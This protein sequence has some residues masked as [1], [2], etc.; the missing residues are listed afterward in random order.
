YHY[1]KDAIPELIVTGTIFQF[2]CISSITKASP[3]DPTKHVRLDHA[4]PNL[5]L[6]AP[7]VACVEFAPSIAVTVADG[8]HVLD[9]VRRLS[10]PFIRRVPASPTLQA[11]LALF[12]RYWSN[13]AKTTATSSE[14]PDERVD[15]CPKSQRHLRPRRVIVAA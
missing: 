4:D 9:G 2:V 5:G 1:Y 10:T 8:K 7:S 12:D 11:I 6:T 3:F 15:R 14:P 13:V